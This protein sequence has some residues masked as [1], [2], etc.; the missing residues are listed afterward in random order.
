MCSTSDEETCIFRFKVIVEM[1]KPDKLDA[2]TTLKGLD[3]IDVPGSV[4]RDYKLHFF[5]HKE[6]NFGAK[7][8][9]LGRATRHTVLPVNCT[10]LWLSGGFQEWTHRW[11]CLLLRHTAC[12]VTWSNWDNWTGDPGAKVGCPHPSHREPPCI[13]SDFPN[14]VQSTGHQ[15]TPTIHCSA[16]FWGWSRRFNS[17]CFHL[18]A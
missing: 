8:S 9:T 7:V 17:R 11:I 12:N 14:W 5:A 3:Y 18:L 6:G 4:K 10:D 16:E 13:R 15:L 2:G 1:I